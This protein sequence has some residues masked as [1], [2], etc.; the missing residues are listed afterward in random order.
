[1]SR[2]MAVLLA[3]AV[4]AARP[5]IVSAQA[6]TTR[7]R[8]TTRTPTQDTTRRV[9]AEARGETDL[10]SGVVNPVALPARDQPHRRALR[11]VPR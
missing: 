5:V 2:M 8:D 10:Q 11:A 6:D 9:R 7:R 4:F 1:M 3:I